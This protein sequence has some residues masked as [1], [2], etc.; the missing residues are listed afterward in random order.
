MNSAGD[1]ERDR[2]VAAA[3]KLVESVPHQLGARFAGLVRL[4]VCPGWFGE[5]S[6][7]VR[8]YQRVRDERVGTEVGD[9]GGPDQVG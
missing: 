3:E 5:L 6:D 8:D 2:V 7:A 1:K 4:E 9:S